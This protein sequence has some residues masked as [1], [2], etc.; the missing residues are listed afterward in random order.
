MASAEEKGNDCIT[1]RPLRSGPS[2]Q[3]CQ[4]KNQRSCVA[5]TDANQHKR[6]Q[7]ISSE[8][9]KT[10]QATNTFLV[11]ARADPKQTRQADSTLQEDHQ[12]VELEAQTPPQN[13]NDQG[14]QNRQTTD[15]QRGHGGPAR[16][17]ARLCIRLVD[18]YFAYYSDN[19]QADLI[20]AQANDSLGKSEEA[21][22]GLR[23]FS[24]HRTSK[25]YPK[26]CRLSRKIIAEQAK[27]IATESSPEQ[28]IT[29]YLEEL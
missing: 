19:L 28:A 17:E 7:S 22:N 4:N 18:A 5:T 14:Q 29:H 10:I 26:A 6:R 2:K 27:K 20:K 21:L 11:P 15:Q 8:E 13:R 16:Q 25:L 3:P 23:T 1:I 24:S 9:D 12:G